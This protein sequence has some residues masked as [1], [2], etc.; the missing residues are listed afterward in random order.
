MKPVTW[1]IDDEGVA[2]IEAREG[3]VGHPYWPGGASGVTLDPC[4]D[5]GQ[6]SGTEFRSVYGDKLRAADM[7]LL[8]HCIGATGAKAAELANSVEIR[9]I[10]IRPEVADAVL[11]SHLLPKYCAIA[12]DAFPGLGLTPMRVR[13]P[14]V[15][16]CVNRGDIP[17]LGKTGE[18]RDGLSTDSDRY[19]DERSIRELVPQYGTVDHIPRKIAYHLRNMARDDEQGLWRGPKP[20]NPGL[21]RRRVL[22]ADLCLSAEAA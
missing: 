3:R 21:R 19:D 1:T 17:L 14:L 20:P 12:E 8:L 18:A 22:E 6:Y 10:V 2:F 5:L 13:S 9:R 15:S 4:V 11:R 7:D 16:L